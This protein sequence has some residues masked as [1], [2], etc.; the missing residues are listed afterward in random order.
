[1]LIIYIL[2]KKA[3]ILSFLLVDLNRGGDFFL[4]GNVCFFIY[5]IATLENNGINISNYFPIFIIVPI[6]IFL[7]IFLSGKFK[8]FFKFG[9]MRWPLMLY[10]SSITLHGITGLV[11]A[12]LLPSKLLL[13]L[14]SFIF[15]LSDYE[16]VVDRFI[17]PGNK[18]LLR[19]NS[20]F[21]KKDLKEFLRLQQDPLF[22][23]IVDQN[24]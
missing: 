18:W 8:D 21:N 23:A 12:I 1:M 11:L 17:C 20:L 15:M 10:Y 7:W 2:E 4:A 14:W 13:G 19:L 6:L 16:L 24:V 5:E 3:L 22:L 9:K